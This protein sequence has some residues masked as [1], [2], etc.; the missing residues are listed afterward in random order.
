MEN[1]SSH[2]VGLKLVDAAA[3][4]AGRN[5]SSILTTIC[6]TQQTLA[7]APLSSLHRSQALTLE[8]IQG[9]VKVDRSGGGGVRQDQSDNST[10][11]D[12]G[13]VS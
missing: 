7:F 4:G 1:L 11:D 2:T 10:H 9:L 3:R 12:D 13:E 5:T 8:E 6:V